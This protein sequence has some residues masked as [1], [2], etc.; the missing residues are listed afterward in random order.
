MARRKASLTSS[1]ASE[2]LKAQPTTLR[3]NKSR[4]TARYTQPAAVG[5]YVMSVAHLR[6]GA[7]AVKLR[8]SVFSAGCFVGSAW[9]VVGWKALRIL[10]ARPNSRMAAA[11]V[12]RQADSRSSRWR[13]TSR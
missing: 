3:L 9:V 6:L 2:L 13:S 12:L 8:S 1:V 4:T 5:R 11:T 7:S 10:L